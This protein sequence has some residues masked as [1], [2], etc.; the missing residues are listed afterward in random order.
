MKLLH[1]AD[2]HAGRSLKGADRTP[3]VRDALLEIAEVAKTEA[4]DAVLV[5][6]DVFDKRNPPAHAEAAVFDFFLSLAERDIPSIV[7]A[8]NHDSPSRLDALSGL[9][10]RVGARVLGK[11]Q[12]ARAGGAFSLN[13]AGDTL[14]VAALPFTSERVLVRMADVLDADPG[15]WRQRYQEG[16]K[17]LV[18]NLSQHF[19]ADAVNVLMMHTTMEGAT[20]AHSEYQ[21]YCTEDYT[22]M[23]DIIPDS[24]NY[25]ALGHIH[26]PQAIQDYAGQGG[27]YAGSL[28]QLDFGEAGDTKSVFIIDA[29][30]GRPTELIKQYDITSG[31][32]LRQ[33]RVNYDELER[34][35]SE[36][37]TFDGYAKLV[38]N[39]DRPV[40]GLKDRLRREAPNVLDVAV[41][42]PE[43]P[44]EEITGVDFQQVSMIDAFSQYYQ[45]HH[46]TPLDDDVRRAFNELYEDV[47]L[48]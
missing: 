24:C 44:Q 2:W 6:G 15:Q 46:G 27:R 33:F 30:P 48:F 41:I 35:M 16:M 25:V 10:S 22:V 11:A 17:A 42:L 1:T 23:P 14:Q 7:I 4:V 20:L 34:R 26:K 40:P 45:E 3:E 19:A 36:V 13:L 32:Q 9:L 29:K 37:K 39:M 28:L 21:F 47:S 5:A 31:K 18:N 38:I 43:R 8:G 12:V